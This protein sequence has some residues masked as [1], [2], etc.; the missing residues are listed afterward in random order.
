MS[1]HFPVQTLSTFLSPQEA[2]E[3][4]LAAKKSERLREE[5]AAAL[6]AATG[7]L[8]SCR[9]VVDEDSEAARLREQVRTRGV[10][11]RGKFALPAP[12]EHGWVDQQPPCT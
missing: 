8:A 11:G 7:E 6:E 3:A 12:R 10:R 2:R 1:E 9:M 4:V 5:A